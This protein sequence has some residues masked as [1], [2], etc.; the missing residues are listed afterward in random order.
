MDEKTA[1]QIVSGRHRVHTHPH[2]DRE[3]EKD[4]I[5]P[6]YN[7]WPVITHCVKNVGGI[8]F[9]MKKTPKI[10]LKARRNLVGEAVIP[11]PIPPQAPTQPPRGED[12]NP[13]HAT[14]TTPPSPHPRTHRQRSTDP[15]RQ[16]PPHQ[17]PA[18]EDQAR[19]ERR[20]R[21]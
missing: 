15:L 20:P 16:V 1:I 13:P 12:Q 10:E 18:L 19:I 8:H 14:T 5:F 11:E 2:G 9:R 7:N 3:E 6:P 4:G 21:G 17:I